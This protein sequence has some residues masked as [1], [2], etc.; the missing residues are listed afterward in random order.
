MP[1]SEKTTAPSTPTTKS[2]IKSAYLKLNAD[3]FVLPI[4]RGITTMVQINGYVDNYFR[5]TDVYLIVE[6]PGRDPET[7]KLVAADGAYTTQ[8]I[9]QHDSPRGEYVLRTQY[10]GVE[11]DAISFIVTDKSAPKEPVGEATETSA[12][13]PTWV[14]T[15]AAWWADDIISEDEFINA[16]Q[17]LI[18]KGIMKVN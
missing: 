15:N 13:I 14:R 1:E 7:L 12:E 3:E 16:I 8:I 10:Q 6:K 4:A 11:V 5:G 17:Y 2:L 18:E 9:L